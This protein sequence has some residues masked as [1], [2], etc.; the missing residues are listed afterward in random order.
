MTH[1]ILRSRSDDRLVNGAAE[2]IAVMDHEPSVVGAQLLVFAGVILAF[3]AQLNLDVAGPI[4]IEDH[5]EDLLA[6]PQ[7]GGLDD[8]RRREIDVHS[9]V[10]VGQ[11]G[12]DDLRGVTFGEETIARRHQKDARD[13]ILEEGNSKR[14][15]EQRNLK[16]SQASD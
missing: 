7:S 12:G 10:V 4:R 8:G 6:G 1:I 16:F 9:L 5:G 15:Q 13:K 2:Q 14:C 3:T 11:N